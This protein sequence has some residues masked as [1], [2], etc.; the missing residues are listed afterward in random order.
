[1]TRPVAVRGEQAVE[2]TLELRVNTDPDHAAAIAARLLESFEDTIG[3]TLTARTVQ[4]DPGQIIELAGR[5]RRFGGSA[6]PLR[7]EPDSRRVLLSGEVLEFTRLEFDLLLFLSRNPDRVFDR[8][9]LMAQV[10][11]LS[12]GNGRTVDVHVRKIRGKLEPVL[13]PITTVRGVGYRFDGAG[14]VLIAD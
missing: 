10:W 13:T 12:G 3:V 7:I 4:A 14:Q 1:M 2:L 9:T 11:G 6:P 5:R 8:L